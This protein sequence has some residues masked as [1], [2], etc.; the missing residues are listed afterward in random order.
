MR[1]HLLLALMI[2]APARAATTPTT[3][4]AAYGSAAAAHAYYTAHERALVHEVRA[5]RSLLAGKPALTDL[6]AAGVAEPEVNRAWK[7]LLASY[8]SVNATSK[9]VLVGLHRRIAGHVYLDLLRPRFELAADGTLNIIKL[10][11]PA[12][13]Y[14]TDAYRAQVGGDLQQARVA[15]RLLRDRMTY[16]NKTER[17]L[18]RVETTIALQRTAASL[19]VAGLPSVN[20]LM[21]PWK[22]GLAALSATDPCSPDNPKADYTRLAERSQW[23]TDTTA[24]FGVTF[25]DLVAQLGQDCAAR[26]GSAGTAPHQYGSA[27]DE[28]G[29]LG[30]LMNDF[31]EPVDYGMCVAAGLGIDQPKDIDAERV[32]TASTCG[33]GGGRADSND[34]IA[35]PV[36]PA[37]TFAEKYAEKYIT[38]EKA[39]G[40]TP[41]GPPPGDADAAQRE[42]AH[43]ELSG[44]IVAAVSVASIVT[45]VKAAVQKIADATKP[46]KAPPKTDTSATPK[47]NEN[48]AVPAPPPGQNPDPHTP[49]ASPGPDGTGCTDPWVKMAEE[50]AT[51]VVEQ[52]FGR[53]KPSIEKKPGEIDPRVANIWEGAPDQGAQTL[54]ACEGSQPPPKPS[55]CAQLTVP[56]SACGTVE[57]NAA[58][59]LFATQ[60]EQLL[61]C[62]TANCDPSGFCGCLESKPQT[63]PWPSPGGGGDPVSRP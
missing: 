43:Q 57:V 62:T 35:P 54:Q 3:V 30:A 25:A 47:G 32:K 15:A 31:N 13:R 27:G 2:A 45:V 10:D 28:M 33:G 46:D 39:K 48:G 58:A 42:E 14:L 8:G 1:V 21:Q 41:V 26:G 50:C 52:V 34:L 6:N 16:M 19:R 24:S 56:P 38:P 63:D 17:R 61:M 22:I 36:P 23:E 7:A 59:Q 9:S 29:C 40:A 4:N 20:A 18:M 55:T 44:E 5:A 51:R 53:K 60:A 49:P 37:K 11:I 12:V